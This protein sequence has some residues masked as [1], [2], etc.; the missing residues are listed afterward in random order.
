MKYFISIM[1][2]SF[3]LFGLPTDKSYTISVCTIKNAENAFTCIDRS[4]HACKNVYIIGDAKTGVYRANCEA[5]ATYEEA[6]KY[7]KTLPDAIKINGP[8]VKQ[9][10]F[11]ILEYKSLI[12]TDKV[13]ILDKEFA[14]K[15]NYYKEQYINNL[16]SN[17]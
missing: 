15:N 3:Y 14:G 16:L 2:M 9:Y 7:E 10:D 8:F 4:L 12:G 5:F 11:N 1:M 17:R 6:K 13:I